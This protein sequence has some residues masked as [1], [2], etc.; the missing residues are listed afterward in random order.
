M[1]LFFSYSE[2]KFL[3]SCDVNKIDFTCFCYS[4]LDDHRYTKLTPEEIEKISQTVATKW[5]RLGFDLE[6]PS[7]QFEEICSN[8]VKYPDSLTKS[9]KI[10]E[11]FNEQMIFDRHIL[12]DCLIK[13]YLDWDKILSLPKQVTIRYLFT[14]FFLSIHLVNNSNMLSA[15][16]SMS[17]SGEPHLN[18]S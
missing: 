10:L 11:I 16:S 8:R 9:R 1:H 4:I 7:V 15:T 3:F 14:Y 2:S 12:N 6:I 5:I 17:V 18:C 13:I